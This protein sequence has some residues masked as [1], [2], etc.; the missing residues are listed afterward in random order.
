MGKQLRFASMRS[1][2]PPRPTIQDEG[3]ALSI[4]RR[5]V[6]EVNLDEFYWAADEVPDR[7][8]DVQQEIMR[9]GNPAEVFDRLW[10]RQPPINCRG[11]RGGH[12]YGW[13]CIDEHCRHIADDIARDEL[14]KAR[15]A[16][17]KRYM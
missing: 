3:V 6:A 10:C 14:A 13:E 11:E 15:A 12:P 9:A 16:Y 8:Y 1:L 17:A 7:I 5:I 4:A 2:R